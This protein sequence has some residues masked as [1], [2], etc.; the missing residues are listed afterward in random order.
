[1]QIALGDTS[2][3]RRIPF[4]GC[5]NFRDLGGYRTRDGLVVRSRRLFRADGPHALTDA[6]GAML[7]TLSVT[8]VLDL[9]TVDEA[10]ERG[11]YAAVVPHVVTHPLPMMDVLPEMDALESWADPAVV[12]ARYREMLESGHESICEALAILTDPDTFP[13]LL[14]CSAGKDRTGILSAIVLGILGVPDDTIIDDYALSGPAM[15][16]LIEHLHR[17]FPDARERLDRV[18]P[19]MLAADPQSMQRFLATLRA[20]HG[21][22]EGYVS[23]LGMASV[24]PYLRGTLLA[25]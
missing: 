24:V 15:V 4:D 10:A 11:H 19:A 3:E 13:A 1:M 23:D 18:A 6:D 22:F 5:F 25:A 8:T 14:H 7:R 17:T 12:A 2:L 21:S 20:E 16:L 9:R